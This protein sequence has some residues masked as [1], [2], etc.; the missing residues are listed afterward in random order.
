MRGYK[1]LSLSLSPTF[2]DSI[3]MNFDV[4]L[5]F[6]RD[7]KVALPKKEIEQVLTEE[8][9]LFDFGFDCTFQESN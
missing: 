2:M 9:I 8:K 4:I 6:L 3:G 1:L 7:G 5:D